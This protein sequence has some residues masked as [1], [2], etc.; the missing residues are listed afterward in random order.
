MFEGIKDF[1]SEA[2]NLI[3]KLLVLD[4]QQRITAEEALIHPFF[5]DIQMEDAGMF[6]K[7]YRINKEKETL[8]LA[9]IHMK[10]IIK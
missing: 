3:E 9:K 7:N 6:M 5:K 4:P 1:P 10:N 2:F 8:E